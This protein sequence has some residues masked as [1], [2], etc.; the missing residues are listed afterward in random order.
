MFGCTARVLLTTQAENISVIDSKAKL[1]AFLASYDTAQEAVLA[2]M[3]GGS[4]VSCTDPRIGGV[5]AVEGGCEVL[6]PDDQRC[7]GLGLFQV[8]QRVDSSGNMTELV[9]NKVE[10]GLLGCVAGRRPAGLL[11]AEPR[12]A[13]PAWS[14]PESVVGAYFANQARLESA[15][16][17]A[18]RVLR[19]ELASHG[20]PR[21]LTH[22]IVPFF[23]DC[24]ASGGACCRGL[25]DVEIEG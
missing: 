11:P 17:T 1:D 13:Q 23:S 10:D 20:A 24:I 3:A 18:F 14:A 9:R 22:A 12:S 5:R 8:V 7:S 25:R 16:V 19:R 6:V 21:R 4:L 15:A 2:A